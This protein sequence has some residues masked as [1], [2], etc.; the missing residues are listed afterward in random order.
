MST[1]DKVIASGEVPDIIFGS[2][3]YFD[4]FKQLDILQDLSP[5]VKKYNIDLSVFNPTAMDVIKQAGEHGEIYSVPFTLN[6]GA[7]FYNKDIFDKFGVDYPKDL[8]SWEDLIPVAKKLTRLDG[9]TQ[10]IGLSPPSIGLLINGMGLPFVPANDKPDLTASPFQQSF[11]FIQ[12]IFDIPGQVGPDNKFTYNRNVFIKDRNLAMF[13]GW[14]SDMSVPLEEGMQT[15]FTNWD[16]SGNPNFKDK[17]GNGRSVDFHLSVVS[18]TSKA[19][20]QA[21]LVVMESVSKETQML[22]SANGNVSGLNG[23]EYEDHFAANLQSYKGKHIQNIFK[24]KM[25]SIPPESQYGADA[26]KFINDALK[27]VETKQADIN[28]ALREAQEKTELAIKE[29]KAAGE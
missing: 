19:K 23:K 1:L 13:P 24:T 11:S 10:Y 22:A 25:T 15:G 9:G 8:M 5:Y 16:L 4:E 17:L 7:L 12:Q 28:T 3:Y 27:Q 29:K 26:R 20:E 21:F 18:K 6:Y 2:Q 14:T